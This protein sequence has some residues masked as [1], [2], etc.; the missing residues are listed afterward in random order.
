[1]K[2]FLMAQ[3]TEREQSLNLPPFTIKHNINYTHLCSV[4]IKNSLSYGC[5]K[6]TEK[7]MV[8]YYL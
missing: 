7:T 8:L 5:K 4:I 2:Y 1:M 6:S 3:K